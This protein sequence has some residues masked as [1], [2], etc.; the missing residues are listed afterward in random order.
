MLAAA[1]IDDDPFLDLVAC[2]ARSDNLTFLK[3]DGAGGF[4]VARTYLVGDMPRSLVA[5]DLDGNGLAEVI[6]DIVESGRTLRENGLEI[7]ETIADISA[8]MVVNR[9]SMKMKADRINPMIQAVRQQLDLRR[10]KLEEE[11]E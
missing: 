7:L 1:I 9:V 6:V 10:R 5:V 3:G 2:N 4:T 8:R 11:R